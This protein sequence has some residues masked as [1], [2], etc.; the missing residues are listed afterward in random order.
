MTEGNR[1]CPKPYFA[2]FIHRNR[3]PHFNLQK[4][5][6]TDICH[7]SDRSLR[8]IYS[9]KV[10]HVL[11]LF[12]VPKLIYINWEFFHQCVV[13]EEKQKEKEVACLRPRS[14]LQPHCR[15]LLGL[16]PV[17]PESQACLSK[18]PLL[19]DEPFFKTND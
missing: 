7:F 10:E 17:I 12:D 19:M 9:T 15:G 13:V 16:E 1:F 8:F 6:F 5:P 18:P 4:Q 2:P 14:S 11:Q 3:A